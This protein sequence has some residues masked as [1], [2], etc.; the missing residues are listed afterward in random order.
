[1]RG[2]IVALAILVTGI[3]P[4]VA[5]TRLPRTTP[6]ERQYKELNRSINREQRTMQREQQYQMDTNQLRQSYDRQRNLANPS[7]PASF[8]NCPGGSIGC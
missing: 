3:V 8:R 5:Q 6:S 2:L 1:M 4:A 7:P